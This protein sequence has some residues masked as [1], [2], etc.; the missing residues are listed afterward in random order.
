[1]IEFIRRLKMELPIAHR[2]KPIFFSVLLLNLWGFSSENLEGELSNDSFNVFK[3]KRIE[4]EYTQ[5]LKKRGE[6]GVFSDKELKYI[7]M[8]I[9]GLTTGQVY[10]GGDGKLWYWDIFNINRIKP[11]R[12]GAGD[13]F[14]LNPMTQDHRFEQGF[15]IRVNKDITSF[16]KKLSTGG[17]SDIIFRGEYPIGKVIYKDH[18][19]P[20]SVR[21]EAFSPFIPTNFEKSDFPA[22]V[23][24]YQVKNESNSPLD[25]EIFGWLQNTANLFISKNTKGKH[26]NTIVN[27]DGMLQLVNSSEVNVEAQDAP[28][29]GNMSL[30]LLNADENSW[31]SPKVI[32]DVAYNSSGIKPSKA[33]KSSADLGDVLTG[34]VGQNL[35]LRANEEKT[36]TFIVSWYFPNVHKVKIPKLKNHE[37]LR[38]YYSKKFK[39]S[40]DVATKINQQKEILFTATKNWN[41]TWYDSSLPY[42]FLD[43]TFINASTLATASCYRF[44]DLTH[45][46]DNEGRFYAM[47]GV[48][49]G[50]GTCTHVFHYEQAMGRLFPNMARQLRDQIDFGL[51]WDKRGFVR[52]RAEHSHI[53]KHDGRGFAIDGHAGTLL[54]AYREHT[55]SKDS[56]FLKKNWQKIKAGIKYLIAQ[57][58]EKTGTPDGIIEGSQYHTLD[59]PWYGKISW[60]TGMYNATLQVGIALGNEIGDKDFV[61]LCQKIADL[62][63][64]NIPKELFNGEF[65][66]NELDPEHLDAPNTNRG[67]HLD[68]VLGQS[69]ALQ[70]GL[71]RILPKDKTNMALSSIFRYNYQ[72]DVGKYLDT[73]TIK[74]VRF[75]ALPKEAGTIM[76]TFPN[77]GAEIAPGKIKHDW[78]KL[79]VGYFSECMTGFTYQAAGHMIG[80]GLIDEG[81]IIIKAI[82]DRYDPLKRNPYNEI[83][84]GNHYIRAMASYGAFIAASGFTC[85]GPKGEI[86]FDPKI[87]PDDFKSAFVTAEGWGS[88][89]QQRKNNIQFA[90]IKLKY[91]KLV[92]Q[93]ININI[94][95][96]KTIYKVTVQLNNQAVQV[97]FNQRGDR[98]LINF[99]KMELQEGDVIDMVVKY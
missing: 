25:I 10:L 69:W 13:K 29:Y 1:M 21:L 36:V 32:Q 90:T 84:Y 15:S 42:W 26:I 20:V 51:S 93:K 33:T 58:A 49:L 52:Y 65:F 94:P 76:C 75:Y 78:D 64:E 67:C 92:L 5:E 55:M 85:H 53:G 97:R 27:S 45:N 14:Y 57:D 35:H 50:E 95:N 16:S 63:Y 99:D 62:G 72:K 6:P 71:P 82:H 37:N 31:A 22:I 46:P 91:G 68:Q 61:N 12:P 70:V 83:E 39:S 88:F 28:D 34:A 7:G 3:Q 77:G 2:L 23:M 48:Y 73:A 56:E 24:Q 80:E 79:T 66:V 18:D 30:S 60:I 74:N 40:A 44:N 59:R 98:L 11:T 19:I 54:R 8:P 47:E 89:T 38:Y 17:F 4:K 86:G 81:L 43:R 9:G 87:N 41:K 96:N